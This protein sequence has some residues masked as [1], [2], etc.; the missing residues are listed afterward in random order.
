MNRCKNCGAFIG[1]KEHTCRQPWNKGKP[2]MA[3]D[4]N[5]RWKGGVSNQWYYKTAKQLPK[6]CV[7]CNSTEN[8]VIHHKNRNHE[9]NK[10]ENLEWL[11]A[12]CHIIIEHKAGWYKGCKPWNTG[13]KLTEEHKRKIGEGCKGKTWYERTPEIREKMRKAKE[14]YIPWNK[15]KNHPKYKEYVE[16]MRILAREGKVG[17]QS[18]R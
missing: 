6:K 2:F 5:P 14:D 1:K 7:K 18:K 4:K 12:R 9:D 3:G 10:L 17:K 13:K 15:N 16:K 8:L 11:C